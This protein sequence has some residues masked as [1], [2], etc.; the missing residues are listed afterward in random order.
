MNES[1]QRK[2]ER[3]RRRWIDWYAIISPVLLI[4]LTNWYGYELFGGWPGYKFSIVR[5]LISLLLILVTAL[6]GAV[7]STIAAMRRSLPWSLLYWLA[8][9]IDVLA[10]IFFCDHAWHVVSRA[11]EKY[12][13]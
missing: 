11:V 4:P 10:F 5:M 7:V 6:S 2:A 9:T 8:G 3:S 12:G 13:G 1:R